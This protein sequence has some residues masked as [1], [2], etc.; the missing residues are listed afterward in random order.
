MPLFGPSSLLLLSSPFTHCLSGSLSNT[1]DFPIPHPLRQSV[2][3]DIER[4][5][6]IAGEHGI[7]ATDFPGA[8]YLAGALNQALFPSTLG[9]VP[10]RRRTKTLTARAQKASQAA[11]VRSARNDTRRRQTT[12]TRLQYHEMEVSSD[13]ND[14]NASDSS[15]DVPLSLRLGSVALSN[16]TPFTTPNPSTALSD[17]TSFTTPNPSSQLTYVHDVDGESEMC[18]SDDEEGSHAPQ[19]NVTRT[20]RPRI[21]WKITSDPRLPPKETSQLFVKFC[22]IDNEVNTAKVK[23][24]MEHIR[25]SSA[26]SEL[27]DATTLQ[28]IVTRCIITETEI[29]TRSFYHLVS[30]LQYTV[31]VEQ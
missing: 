18:L 28:E 9:S 7:S 15:S 6:G 30:L 19:T 12:R 1:M 2:L 22:L 11:K 16:L 14:G 8:S 20:Q 21:A 25:S 29:A 10:P 17:L 13:A 26:M 27:V 24:L 4:L 3:A 31:W 23:H 5:L